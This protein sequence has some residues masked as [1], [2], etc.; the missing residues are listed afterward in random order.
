MHGVSSAV[1][2]IEYVL[3]LLLEVAAISR[4]STFFT[5]CSL[6]GCCRTM[7]TSFATLR[8]TA[9]FEHAIEAIR[10]ARRALIERA[11][12]NNPDVKICIA[13]VLSLSLRV[14]IKERGA[15]E[16]LARTS[17]YRLIGSD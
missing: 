9:M 15:R 13:Q 7:A 3:G 4:S 17:R 2:A 8:V 1:I 14:S 5:G 16:V 6:P 12:V 11:F 10:V